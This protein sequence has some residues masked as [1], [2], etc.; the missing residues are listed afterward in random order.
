MTEN[1]VFIERKTLWDDSIFEVTLPDVDNNSI[2]S[3]CE[4]EMNNSVHVKRSN[5]GGWQR[6]VTPGECIA[7]DQL[8]VKLRS[9]VNH[10]T[11]HVWE[12]NL[13]MSVGNAWVNVNGLANRNGLHTHPGSLV[14]GVY[15]VKVPEGRV[16]DI[17]MVRDNFHSIAATTHQF[18]I[19]DK[20]SVQYNPQFATHRSLPASEH[21]AFCFPSWFAHEV[22]LNFTDDSRISVGFNF[23]PIN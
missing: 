18:K 8:L 13:R 6:D 11:N 22:G 4:R 17:R 19:S 16:G 10:V 14:S 9:V 20:K 21:K 23:I 7:L 1:D 12:L 2:I 3:F 15:Y 5:I